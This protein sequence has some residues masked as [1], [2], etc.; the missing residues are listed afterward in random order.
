MF[1]IWDLLLGCSTQIYLRASYSHSLNF[2]RPITNKNKLLFGQLI[3]K[4]CGGPQ[5]ITPQAVTLLDLLREILASWE[6]AWKNLKTEK[7]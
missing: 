1:S 5:A 7:L 2:V 4:K 3:A 6:T